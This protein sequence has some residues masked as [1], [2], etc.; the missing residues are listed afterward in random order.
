M[1]SKLPTWKYTGK[2]MTKE[3]AE[4]S[5]NKVK[6]ACLGCGKHSPDCSIAK[7]VGDISEMIE[8]SGN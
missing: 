4:E 8:K 5:L 6:T 1:V 2:E 7:A 3:K